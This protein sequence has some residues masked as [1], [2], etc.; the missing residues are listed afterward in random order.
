L[1]LYD[2]QRLR[3]PLWKGEPTA[4]QD[5]DPRIE[6]GLTS[7]GG[8]AVRLLTETIHSP[9]ELAAIARFGER[10]E[11][12]R[13]ITYDPLS[14]SAIL[15]AHAMTHG[16]RVLPRYHFEAART[17]VSFD[18]DFLATW[19]SPV[20]H[21]AGYGRARDL[22]GES[23]HMSYH[24]QVE[25]RMSLTGSNADLRIAVHPAE[26][27]SWMGHLAAELIRRA[28]RPFE[29][30]F[31][32]QGEPP[33]SMAAAAER[34]W[35]EKGHA[36]V[37]CGSQ[38][39]QDQLLCNLINHLLDGYGHCLDLEHPSHQ[40]KGD[41]R[42]LAELGL[43]LAAGEV[44]VL[45]LR[46]VNPA[47][48]LPDCKEWAARISRV[49]L[50]V[51]LGRGLDE[52]ASVTTAVCPESHFLEDWRDAE[53]VLGKLSLTQPLIQPL[54]Q[55]R[56]FA[57][58]LLT[59]IGEPLPELAWLQQVWREEIWSGKGLGT[60][61]AR[62]FQ[63]FWDQALHDGFVEVDQGSPAS[64]SFDPA[65]LDPVAFA[66][67]V[68]E[69]TTPSAEG[70]L[71]LVLYPKP[72]ILDGRHAHNAWLQELPDPVTKVSWD[73]Y[74][75]LSPATASHLGLEEGDLV[76]IK[77]A[78][79]G[80][81]LVLPALLQPGQHDGAVAVAVGY[82]R[83]GTD[84]FANAGPTWL[85]GKP[86]VEEG[87]TVG[88]RAAEWLQL[89]QGG[90]SPVVHGV[91]VEG[92]GGRRPLA[93]IQE[94]EDLEVP[95]PLRP[96]DG[97]ARPIVQ[98]ASLAAYLEDPG[99]GA[100]H[101]HYPEAN[102]WPE[103]PP[104][105]HHWGMAIDLTAC[106][107]CSA[108]VIA[109]QVENNVPVVGRD[110]VRRR[111]DLYWMRIDRY[112]SRNGDEVEVAHQ[113]MLCHHCDNAPCESVCPVLA[114][115]HSDEGLNQQV[116][117]RCVG[118]RYCANNCPFKVRRFNWFEYQ[119][120]D[121]VANLALNPDVTVRSRGVMEKCSFCVQRIQEAKISAGVRG[122]DLAPGAVQTAC[123]QSCP[124][125]AIVFGDLAN[126]ESDIAKAAT[127][128]RHYR[129]F[130]ELNIQPSVGYQRLIRNR[131]EE[132]RGHVDAHA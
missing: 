114:T 104:G 10:F 111:R 120:E 102:L 5:L 82:G 116:Y 105:K 30:P 63:D 53:P 97:H 128:P 123:Q 73:N 108:C 27:T 81:E 23:P 19:I 88:V 66:A 6:G 13:H 85:E 54:G 2:S 80:E 28:G 71:S 91:M 75:C 109:C 112:Y 29:L 72:G 68:Q 93:K 38:V 37:V 49:P 98:Q 9:S 47:Y 18:A 94:Y 58:S 89:Y 103:Y 56:G 21:T 55:T 24:L 11:D 100:P 15:D 31:S 79:E 86:T 62:D 25:S 14:R 87:E 115:V 99:A 50:S 122:E 46:G 32:V 90:L 34:L 74:A 45:L 84:R 107:G 48:D 61:Q 106:T 96:A 35:H 69:T 101:G 83:A 33:P 117:N 44:E 132:E 125:G 78:V 76:R 95:E 22:T 51:S 12:F 7:V 129:L 17:L 119:R 127:D 52:T 64:A 65:F 41:D 77:G 113:P 8:G 43:E 118:T 67:A 70:S 3:Q 20:E 4:W 121:A 40:K 59:W 42:A 39:L 131:S 92:A 36:L 1:E 57:S 126:P 26:L 110:E 130:E 16:V 124:A 60:T